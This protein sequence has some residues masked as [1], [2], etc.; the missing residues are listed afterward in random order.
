MAVNV[1]VGSGG[2]GDIPREYLWCFH[3]SLYKKIPPTCIHRER[4]TGQK[5]AISE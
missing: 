1:R 5:P 2:G 3:Y 4:Y